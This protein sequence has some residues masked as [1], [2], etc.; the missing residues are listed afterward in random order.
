MISFKNLGYKGYLGNQ[1]FQYAT[2]KGLATNR[3][4]WYSV[5]QREYELNQ[6]FKISPTLS[7]EFEKTIS[8]EKFE[9]DQILFNT[10][11]DNINLDGYFQTEKYFKHIEDD[12]RKDFSFHKEIYDPSI[13]YMNSMFYGIEVIS[14]HIRRGD[15][16]TD[17]SFYPLSL[18]YYIAALEYLPKDIPVLVISNDPEW[19]RNQ[20]IL[21]SHNYFVISSKNAY[22]DLCLMSLC[23]YHIIANSTFSWW[24]SWLAKSK[25]TIAPKQWFSPTGPLK[26][27]DTKDLYLPEWELI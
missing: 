8:E 5:P 19:C 2:L 18:D 14:L 15:Y 16:V 3:G 22:I 25:K 27:Y 6:C 4:Y 12:I 21:P 9:F 23:D 7:D 17:P 26:H 20:F 24:G 13:H 11:P 1:M 10:C